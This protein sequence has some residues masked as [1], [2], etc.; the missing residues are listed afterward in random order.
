MNWKIFKI[1]FVSLT[2]VWIVLS[3]V[4]ALT[5]PD[6]TE[7]LTTVIQNPVQ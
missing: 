5:S 3:I 7:L 6:S 4:V 1:T 2:V